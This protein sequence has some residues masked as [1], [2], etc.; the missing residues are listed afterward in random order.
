ML[1]RRNAMSAIRQPAV[2]GLFYP[3]KPAELQQVIKRLLEHAHP[4]VATPPK[5]LIVPHAGYIYS[6]STAAEAFATLRQRADKIRRVVLLGPSHR[7]GFGGIAFCSADFYR[8]PLG[9]IPVD[10]SAFVAIS[11]L[12]NVGML[13]RAH[14]QEHCLEVQLPFLQ[15]ILRDFSLVPLVVGD[16]DHDDVARVLEK[17]WGGDETL[18]LISS[19]LSHYHDYAT[20]HALDKRT[21]SAIEQCLPDAIGDEQ[22]CGRV[23]VKGLLALARRKHLHI[24]TLALC[25]SGDTAGDRNRVVGYGAWAFYESEP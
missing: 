11:N 6:G 13:D 10:Q 25:N 16:V 8:T 21:C 17:L 14:S 18:I 22:A 15:T 20:A 7:V 24:H 3:E 12:P 4:T 19:D 9:D 1:P 2:A 23:P 5:A